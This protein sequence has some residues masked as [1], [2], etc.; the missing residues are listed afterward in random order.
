MLMHTDPWEIALH[1]QAQLVVHVGDCSAPALPEKPTSPLLVSEMPL[2]D[3]RRSLTALQTCQLVLIEAYC[4][5]VKKGTF[6]MGYEATPA[7]MP[8]LHP[9]Q[10]P[11]G[12][13]FVALLIV[14]RHQPS[15]D[16]FAGPYAK[17]RLGKCVRRELCAILL[18][19]QKMCMQGPESSCYMRHM[20]RQF[21]YQH[22]WPQR[23]VDWQKECS[24]LERLEMQIVRLPLLSMMT[25]TAMC[26]VENEIERLLVLKKL[27][28]STCAVLRGGA[29]FFLG[30][31]ML[32]LDSHFDVVAESVGTNGIGE[33]CVSLMLTL[34]HTSGMAPGG[35]GLQTGEV[36]YRAPYGAQADV[37]AQAMLRAALGPHARRLRVGPYEPPRRGQQSPSVQRLVSPDNLRRGARV[38]LEC[39]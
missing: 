4:T 16:V 6:W 12:A 29:F 1:H 31:C 10:D 32:D 38:L 3:E 30:S 11:S 9:I 36:L 24:N 8:P 5:F 37:A 13:L 7:G 25:T 20:M 17:G 27:S 34:L 22:E 39:M 14:Q 2:A 26:Q 15:A 35:R 28:L 19:C 33:G 21:L 18:V 23:E